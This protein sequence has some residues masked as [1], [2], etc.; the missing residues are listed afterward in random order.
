LTKRPPTI[1]EEFFSKI[2]KQLQV[3]NKLF[4]ERLKVMEKR[5]DFMQDETAKIAVEEQAFIK[6]AGIIIKIA[7]DLMDKQEKPKDEF[8]K[9]S[10]SQHIQ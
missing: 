7:N 10:T 2:V 5:L 3:D 1:R 8:P 9:D 4:V 6:G